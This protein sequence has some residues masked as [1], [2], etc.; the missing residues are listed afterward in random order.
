MSFRASSNHQRYTVPRKSEND[1]LLYRLFT[2]NNQMQVLCISDSEADKAA[3]AMDVN[4]GSNCD[5]DYLQGLAHFLE[6][7]LFMG[8]EKY[9][10]ENDYEKYLSEHGGS[11]N[12]FT[13]NES[14]N[15]YFDVTKDYLYGALDRFAQF[16][17][18]P[19]FD[20][21]STER[22]L[23]AVDSENA[24]NLN[25][26][27]WRISQVTKT[28][29]NPS[30][31]ASRFSSGNFVSLRDEPLKLGINVRD[32]LLKFHKTY[33]SANLMKL[34]V[35]GR[36][37]LDTLEK[38]VREIF[39]AVP[40]KNVKPID[41]SS[42]PPFNADK[43][44][45][46]QWIVPVKD[47]RSVKLLWPLP[48]QYQHYYEKPTQ[49]LS[50]LLG[51]EGNESIFALIKKKGWANRLEAGT[52]MKH[53]DF[54][55]FKVD[56]DLT[57]EGFAHKYDIVDIVFQ[58]LEILKRAKPQEWIFN[59]LKTMG[60]I[61]FR[62][63]SKKPP[64]D[65][66]VQLAQNM[67]W[68]APEDV[69]S[70]PY[71]YGEF[72][73]DVIEAVQN[74]LN[75]DNLILQ[76]I[77]KDFIG[78]TDSTE[79]WYRTQ[80]KTQKISLNLIQ[81]WKNIK[82]FEPSLA[83]PMKNEFIPQNLSLA[84]SPSAEAKMIPDLVKDSQITKLWH[85]QDNIFN[86][87]KCRLHLQLVTPEAYSSPADTLKTQLLGLL[88]EDALNEFTY[89]ADIAGLKYEINH[90]PVGLEI[91]VKGYNDKLPYLTSTII[92]K[93]KQLQISED[94]FHVL[95]K[96][97]K[98]DLKNFG[99]NQPHLIGKYFLEVTTTYP[100]YTID[101][102]LTV[103]DYITK[104]DTQTFHAR[105]LDTLRLESLAHGNIVKEDALL[106]IDGI[107]TILQTKPLPESL[108]PQQRVV[109]LKRGK[110]YI[111]RT[112]VI[113][114]G[115]ENSAVI[116]WYQIGDQEVLRERV[117]L[118]LLGEI[119][120]ESF[121]HTLR[122]KEQLGYIAWSGPHFYLGVQGYRTI[123]QSSVKDPVYLNSRIENFLQHAGEL[124]KKMSDEEYSH[125]VEALIVKKLE[126][127]QNLQQ[128]SSR[129]WAEIREHKY[130]F[131][132]HKKDAEILKRITRD[133]LLQFF[134]T[135]VQNPETRR[136]ISIQVFGNKHE[137]PKE[138][139]KERSGNVVF[140]DD[141]ATF[142]KNMPLYPFL[143]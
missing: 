123:V 45:V 116:N 36:E 96:K 121:F 7:M 19:L 61:E 75:P 86:R 67:Q 80:Y 110:E 74:C 9:P 137:I 54:E 49:Y 11:S 92:R 16:F 18:C 28:N 77:S 33:Y 87:P 131:D 135:F 104:E 51:H 22:E 69:I 85:L 50:H 72:K 136:K 109:K 30:H 4:V 113:N 139:E 66:C 142:K 90:Y 53:K 6:H 98:R 128:L 94:R 130:I 27:S 89:Y 78:Q 84:P 132:R 52:F 122:T 76:I 138:N 15:Y 32:E 115:D 57:E 65:Y 93:L 12:A 58:Y 99:N 124:L 8:S 141:L 125:H 48:P 10:S 14:T 108:I 31:P 34:A 111:F 120:E 129:L 101:E 41:F 119:L 55:I 5:P 126:K 95:K 44:S 47:I 70:G 106:L 25:V 56:I 100:R 29:M 39:E 79:K 64:D 117:M 26:D 17:I 60:D 1:K 103:I 24:K 107:E 82:E 114:K 83:L 43:L 3:A 21:N 133:E 105:F 35:L 140:I 134:E 23:K 71:L 102:K 37:P 38:W 46:E 62:F 112:S 2:L 40:N 97:I 143:A 127:P 59:E 88:C 13:T 20:P 63:V 118:E 81:K 68:Y 73:S 91:I 42:I